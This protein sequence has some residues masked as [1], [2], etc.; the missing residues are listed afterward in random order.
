M[1][2]DNEENTSVDETADD[3][4]N[5]TEDSQDEDEK[6]TEDSSSED[7]SS[8]SELGQFVDPKNIP[9]QLKEIHSKMVAGYTKAQQKLRADIKSLE[10]QL[11]TKYSQAIIKAKALEQLGQNP[12]FQ[13]FYA[14]LEQNRPYGYSSTFNKG[15]SRLNNKSEEEEDSTD[16]SMTPDKIQKLVQK[17]VSDA[18]RP[19]NENK[20]RESYE[21]ARKNLKNFD[22]YRPAITE[23]IHRYP[24]MSIEEAY[25]LAR[26]DDFE[27]DIVNGK[28]DKEDL[29]T[30]KK[31]PRTEKGS[32]SRTDTLAPKVAK[33]IREAID[34]AIAQ[35]T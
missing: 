32:N 11:G 20:T 15:D 35:Q 4:D 22:R 9:P 16:T 6:E 17:A 7:N 30:L 24:N 1:P 5:Q 14:D 12:Q 34:L 2:K 23:I 26:S 8:E 13:L 27:T 28:K 19:F 31:K 10:D 25:K 3:A 29:E 18:L 21:S 33:S